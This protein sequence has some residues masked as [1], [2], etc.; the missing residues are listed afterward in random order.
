MITLKMGD[1]AP[2]FELNDQEGRLIRLS[3]FTGKKIV[4]YFYPRDNTPGCTREACNFRDNYT[5]LRKLNVEILGIS[6]DNKISHKKF[7][8]KFNLPFKL[9][10]DVDKK[11]SKKYGIYELK[12]FMGKSYYGIIRSTFIID[13]KGRIEKIF[14]K[15]SPEAHLNEIMSALKI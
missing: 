2:S 5:E 7:S 1:K 3:D 6:N 15:V 4:L 12:K 10:S 13:E 9:L 8:E 14:Y 11:V